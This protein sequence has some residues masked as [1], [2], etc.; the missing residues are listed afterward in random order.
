LYPEDTKR[1]RYLVKDGRSVERETNLSPDYAL[2]VTES[3]IGSASVSLLD[4]ITHLVTCV[5]T[6]EPS[7]LIVTMVEKTTVSIELDLTSQDLETPVKIQAFA[8][9]SRIR[10]MLADARA[11]LMMI[12]LDASDL[13]PLD[14]DIL[15]VSA[16]MEEANLDYSGAELE[17]SMISFLNPTVA[18]VAISP[19]ALS[20]DWISQSL[21][22]WSQVPSVSA[23][24]TDVFFKAT[25]ILLGKTDEPKAVP[26]IA[27]L[28]CIQETDHVSWVFTLHSD[29]TVRRW[30]LDLASSNLPTESVTLPVNLPD[31]STWINQTQ[32][33]I[34]M[35]SRMYQSAFVIAIHIQSSEEGSTLTVAHGAAG[36]TTISSQIQLTIPEGVTSLVDMDLS[37]TNRCQLL[38]F[39]KSQDQG[40]ILVTYPPSYT[41][42]ISSKPMLTPQEYTL[43]GWAMQE[44]DRIDN[45]ALSVEE[46]VSIGQALHSVDTHYLKALFRPLYPRGNGSVTGPSART[47][48]KTLSK[49]VH[50]YTH[51][52]S[53][54][55]E[56]E[57]LRAIHEWKRLEG[58]RASARSSTA[59]T[60]ARSTHLS[61]Y[62]VYSPQ[63][64]LVRASAEDYTNVDR[65]NEESFKTQIDEHMG[66]WR[67]F[68]QTIW[69]E[70]NMGRNPL[71]LACLPSGRAILVRSTSIS[72]IVDSGA[73][74]ES[75]SKADLLD[76]VALAILERIEHTKEKAFMLSAIEQKLVGFIASADDASGNVSV[77]LELGGLGYWAMNTNMAVRHE[78]QNAAIDIVSIQSTLKKMSPTEVSGW[79]K[80]SPLESSLPGLAAVAVGKS[81]NP[82]NVFRKQL[83]EAQLRHSSCALYIQSMDSVRRLQVGRCL[84]LTG[85]QAPATASRT[86]FRSYLQALATLWSCGQHVPMPS[87]TGW[88]ALKLGESPPVKRLSFGGEPGSLLPGNTQQTTMLDVRMM[89]LSQT[90]ESDAAA[91]V[92]GIIVQ[93]ARSVMETIYVGSSQKKSSLGKPYRLLGK[94]L[95]VLPSPSNEAIASDHPR[96][97]LRLLTP[98]MMIP[99]DEEDSNVR[100]VRNEA[101]AE[102]LLI[103][104]NEQ[105]VASNSLAM[106]KRA[107]TLLA[108]SNVEI[109]SDLNAVQHA[110]DYLIAVGKQRQ[111]SAGLLECSDSLIAGMQVLLGLG[112]DT[113]MEET[114]RLCNQQ[115]ARALFS[116][117]FLA[118]RT[119]PLEQL[120]EP[121]RNAIEMLAGVLLVISNLFSHLSILERHTDRLGRLSSSSDGSATTLL[122]YTQDVVFKMESLLPEAVLKSMPEYISLWSRLFRQ[123]EAARQWDFAYT[124]CVKNP[125]L[126]LRTNNCQRLVK[127]LADAGALR[128]LLKHCG[129]V[130]RSGTT[131]LDM[132]EIAAETLA[133][134]NFSDRYTSALEHPVDYL[135][136]LYALHASTGNWKRAA[137]AMDLRYLD[138]V[139]ALEASA[140]NSSINCLLGVKDI[141][142]SAAASANAMAL[143]NDE[144]DRFLVS[145]EF[146]PYP[147]LPILEEAELA[148]KSILKRGRGNDSPLPGEVDPSSP[149]D[150]RLSRFM[151]ECDLEGRAI[152]ALAFLKLFT[153]SASSASNTWILHKKPTAEADRA[154]L[155]TLASHGYFQQSFLVAKA[156]VAGCKDR[157]G[158]TMPS[159]RDLKHDIVS[160]L[161]LTF[162]APVA[163][164]SKDPASDDVM[165]MEDTFQLQRPTLAQ[166]H[167]ALNDFG[168][169]TGIPSYTCG[170]N[171]GQDIARS[172]KE[173]AA[174][175][176]LR[177]VTLAG[178]S[179]LAVEVAEC[180][181]DRSTCRTKLPSWLESFLL[182]IDEEGGLF[183]KS[184]KSKNKG[185]PSALMGLYLN[186]GLYK[187]ACEVVSTVLS[188]KSRETRAA[189]RLP[190]KG[191][192]DFV[193]YHKIDLLWDLMQESIVS[194]QVIAEE[195]DEM[196]ASR[197]KM[198]ESLAKHFDLMKIS[199]IGMQSARMLH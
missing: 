159:G 29:A 139:S 80:R 10:L 36:A 59:S 25:D 64:I 179:L 114:R 174:M 6:D 124:A 153:D 24:I 60:P 170:P 42:I 57:C 165:D 138:A 92:D 99:C 181:L 133:T 9:G 189:S 43:D 52:E 87:F 192:I 117:L 21:L 154:F 81:N 8:D 18:L 193:P 132:F 105:K 41:S 15:S 94:E 62:E 158:G 145:G 122:A 127:A 185:D 190:E 40:P 169:E 1:R 196:L 160:H 144:S 150:D 149:R 12:D 143:V 128:E 121:E 58:M 67:K 172:A 188:G 134:E 162:I 173:A 183:A 147:S 151:T 90:M 27:A 129:D 73:P 101:V 116:P 109:R 31:P 161:L 155:D 5:K 180:L 28:T 131:G 11:N 191:D 51:D 47:V 198:E 171:C 103:E 39:F 85:I 93:M 19:Y 4:D 76:Q 55:T 23:G 14:V 71:L 164:P 137:Q 167:D 13:S 46:G 65:E 186:R 63:A 91:S 148:P 54:S 168:G 112:D 97:A 106:R 48:Y 142:G 61:I 37:A 100:L 156:M 111:D 45:L 126:E 118:G 107:S 166:L 34:V 22:A 136:C 125:V 3:F 84:L 177:R 102:C 113:I 130:S 32:N 38:A 79:L 44:Y 96:V 194:G 20:V 108:P 175:E 104:S 69:H 120:A 7:V 187:E 78:S 195:K 77:L 141:A 182:G 35:R 140:G 30:K 50:G 98:S 152:R 163:A 17:S 75:S 119:R 26:P 199:Q 49:L 146:G 72:L 157:S 197:T 110:Y 66:R 33:S 82:A 95:G 178:S 70:E 89:Q 86:S 123:A 68:L 135:G 53:R 16:L 2:P 83:V 115:T 184:S 74:P 56:L 88:Q 176:L